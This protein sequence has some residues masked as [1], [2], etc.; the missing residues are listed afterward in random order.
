[1]D[2]KSDGGTR[3]GVLRAFVGYWD[4]VAAELLPARPLRPLFRTA[5]SSDR[6]EGGKR[7]GGREGEREREGEGR[8][9]REV[10]RRWEEEG[11]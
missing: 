1:M 11:E 8:E 2:R 7:E 9:E 6:R 10:V 4:D 3:R 5:V